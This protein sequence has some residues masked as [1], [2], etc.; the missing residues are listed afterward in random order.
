MTSWIFKNIGFIGD[1]LI[2]SMN[3]KDVEVNAI[4]KQNNEK[5]SDKAF[6]RPALTS[7]LSS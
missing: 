1:G 3:N 2:I 6:A 7:M 5:L 4:E